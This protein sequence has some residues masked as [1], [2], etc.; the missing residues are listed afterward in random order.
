MIVMSKS[1]RAIP[2]VPVLTSTHWLATARL[3][4]TSMA[5]PPQ[6]HAG[7]HGRIWTATCNAPAPICPKGPAFK[8]APPFPEGRGVFGV[9]LTVIRILRPTVRIR[10]S[11]L[12]PDRT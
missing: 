5:L 3:G 1:T 4:E 7:R 10:D 6:P 9:C 11:N 8:F 2:W 12:K